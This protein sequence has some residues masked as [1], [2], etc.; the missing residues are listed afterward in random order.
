MA[1]RSNFDI[2]APVILFRT[3]IAKAAFVPFSGR[4]LSAAPDAQNNNINPD[5]RML[6]HSLSVGILYFAAS[7]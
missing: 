4:R 1:Q 3:K 7:P 2:L 6:L 5:A